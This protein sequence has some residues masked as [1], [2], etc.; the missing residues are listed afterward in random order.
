[1]T[2]NGDT[3]EAFLP[4]LETSIFDA[5]T[6][7]M[8]DYAESYAESAL[9]GIEPQYEIGPHQT[10]LILAVYDISASS[11]VYFLDIPLENMGVLLNIP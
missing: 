4:N 2:N 7:Y 10:V 9:Q 1:M 6:Y 5:K 11:T 8:C 3:E